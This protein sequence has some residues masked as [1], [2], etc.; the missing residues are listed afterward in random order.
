MN[1]FDGL[2]A[3]VTGGASGIGA[4]TASQLLT[5]GAR[6]TVLDRDTEGAPDGTTAI[7]CDITDEIR[8]V[9][10]QVLT[11]SAVEVVAGPHPTGSYRSCGARTRGPLYAAG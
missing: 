5:R 10:S 7:R 1:D 2:V 4:A 6:V 11:A 9:A 3:V 8:E